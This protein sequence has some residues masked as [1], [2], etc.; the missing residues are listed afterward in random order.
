MNS[1]K[2][3]LILVVNDDGINAKGIR[4]MIEVM[5]RLGDVIVVAPNSP[6]SGM[7]SAIS[8]NRPV[9]YNRVNL[10]KTPQIEYACK[11]TPVDCVKLAINNILDRK[12]DLCVSGIN[13]GSN[14]SIN[15]LYS[16]T[17]AAAIEGSLDDIPSI[18]FSLL[19]ECE[20]A[21]FSEAMLFVENIS[22]K[23]LSDGLNK[24]ICLNVNIPK[25]SSVKITGIK[26]CR[27]AK[28]NWKE[29]FKSTGN[30][31]VSNEFYLKGKFINY[32]SGK[33][34]DLWALENNFVSIVPI[35][36]DLTS[37]KSI[38]FVSKIFSNE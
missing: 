8:I 31:N 10:D 4:V 25:K 3:P 27:Q 33:D 22:K 1:I 30:L 2:R 17:M 9:S 26:V 24:G 6:Q 15:V 20:D 23:I 34:T 32:D 37:Y 14:S 35:N 12:P 18:G 21:D 36:I 7:S 5:N 19:D 11:G 38:D 13:H 28:A 29:E 16:G